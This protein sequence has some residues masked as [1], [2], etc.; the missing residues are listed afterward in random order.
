M[1]ERE[2]LEQT[3]LEKAQLKEQLRL[4]SGIIAFLVKDKKAF[5]DTE[6]FELTTAQLQTAPSVSISSED[7]VTLE[8]KRV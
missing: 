8:I 3:I 5:K 2:I 4:M 7:G 1:N 6:V